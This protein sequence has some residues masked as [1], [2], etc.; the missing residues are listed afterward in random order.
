MLSST[1]YKV[2]HHGS[3]NAK[4]DA[5]NI[6]FLK[7]INPSIAFISSPFPNVSTHH[8]PQ[9][10]VITRLKKAMTGNT[11]GLSWN[12]PSSFVCWDN[13]TSTVIKEGNEC[14]PIFETCRK[15]PAG[16]LS[17]C[18]NILI[19]SDR[20]IPKIEY[21]P[22]S[23]MIP[24]TTNNNFEWNIGFEQNELKDNKL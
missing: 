17:T 1:V 2:S 19:I 11:S 4:Y 21:V 20:T 22:I 5:N 18:E 10:D 13:N 6:E 12:A 7:A 24:E 14:F 16:L 15:P 9:C 3:A 23:H 8:H